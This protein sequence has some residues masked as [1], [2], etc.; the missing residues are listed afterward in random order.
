MNPDASEQSQQFAVI[1][2]VALTDGPSQQEVGT[3]ID[4]TRAG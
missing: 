3:Q 1:N 2:V 4:S